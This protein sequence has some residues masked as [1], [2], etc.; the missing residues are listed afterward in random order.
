MQAI[1]GDFEQ[2]STESITKQINALSRRIDG[3][4]T[5]KLDGNITNEFWDK[6]NKQWAYEKECL[7][8]KLHALNNSSQTFYDGANLLLDFCKL[9]PDKFLRLDANGKRQV[10]NLIGSNF[11]FKDKELSVELNSVFDL[12]V[13]SPNLR[14]GAGDEA[15]TR[16][17]ILG[18]D[19][20]YH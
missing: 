10:L 5:D 1:K 20:F 18:K 15:R 3:L 19:A 17:I 16:D 6:K 11:I 14:N 4:Y 2:S 7:V 9:T 12:L 8:Q 13:N